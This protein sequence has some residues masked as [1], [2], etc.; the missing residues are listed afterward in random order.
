MTITKRLGPDA[1]MLQTAAEIRAQLDRIRSSAEFD[2][3]E[4]ARKFLTYVIEETIAGRADR[5][6]AY[7]IATE[8]FGRDASFDAQLDPVVRIEAG[9]VR[10]ALERYYL[11]AGG[12]DQLVITIP[13]GG[14][15]PAFAPRAQA[16]ATGVRASSPSHTARRLFTQGRH[17]WTWLGAAALTL[18]AGLVFSV[19]EPGKMV[20]TGDQ[21]ADEDQPSVPRL[22]VM[23]FEDLS[24]TPQSK[25]I[26]RGFADEVIG[27]VAKFREIVVLT[28]ATSAQ[29][30]GGRDISPLYALQGSV[31]LEGGRFRLGVRVIRSDDGSVLWANTYDEDLDPLSILDLQANAA[32]AVAT[33]IAQPYGII[34]QADAP[35]V[36]SKVPNDWN[37]YACTLAYYGYR[38]DLN[39]QAHST[40]KDCLENTTEQF[41][42]YA[43]AW[44]LLALTYIDQLRFRYGPERSSPPALDL[45]MNAARRAVELD[46]QNVRGLQAE[47]LVRYFRGEVD[48]ALAVGKRALSINP[49]DTELSA[50]YGFR[51]ALSGQWNPGCK[52]ISDAIA[53]NPG[54]LGYF[55]AA[56][57]VC[58]Y[59]KGDYLSAER[60]SRSADLSGNPVFHL[61]L[62]ATLG[63]LGKP[64]EA[65]RELHWLENNAPDFLSDVP[66]EVGL[67]I[68]RSE[69]QQH[70]IEGL[71]QAGVSIP[72]N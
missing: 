51:L 72:E 59:M 50:E 6:K 52:S 32:A 48:M 60:W 39:P 43:T 1:E 45:A 18:V 23:P 2:A 29:P 33:A 54:L 57:A 53:Q 41:P 71:R 69:D 8:V 63:K 22:L 66:R 21:N 11:L 56:L 10:R 58:S 19:L 30:G 25:M 28:D 13:K 47:M 67:R 15:V 3:P 26:T 5:I 9:R 27:K 62:L 37:A 24:G 36:S 7:S 20:G 35:Q 64:K 31:R 40:V 12:D 46:P 49:N 65:S 44:A 16:A 38:A 70:F 17:V 61:I 4:R 55:E 14:Y 68:Q 42:K 34:F